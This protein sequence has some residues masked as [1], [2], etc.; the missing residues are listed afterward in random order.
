MI[1]NKIDKNKQKKKQKQK[2]PNLLSKEVIVRFS[3]GFGLQKGSE[4]KLANTP[5]VE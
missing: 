1:S 4:K 3:L 2:N 5:P